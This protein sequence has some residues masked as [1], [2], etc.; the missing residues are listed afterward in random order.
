MQVIVCHAITTVPRVVQLDHVKQNAISKRY[1]PYSCWPA[2]VD[3]SEGEV[4]MRE[5]KTHFEQVPVEVAKK[6]AEQEIERAKKKP[7]GTDNVGRVT[8]AQKTE[9]YSV[10]IR[11]VCL[12]G[13]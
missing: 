6:I 11:L 8:P 7:I 4:E 10:N 9:P 12:D 13:R 5:T 3:K 2:T 1:D